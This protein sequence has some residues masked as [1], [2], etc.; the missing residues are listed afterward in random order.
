MVNES[1]LLLKLRDILKGQI[2]LIGPDQKVSRWLWR[3]PFTRAC[4]QNS[5]RRIDST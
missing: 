5:Y 3:S 1:E 2:R 4:E